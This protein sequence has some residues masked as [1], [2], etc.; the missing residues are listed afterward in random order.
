MFI[1]S[2][3]I[4][5]VHAPVQ[6]VGRDQAMLGAHLSGSSSSSTMMKCGSSK[7][8]KIKLKPLSS[9]QKKACLVK[10]ICPACRNFICRPR[11]APRTSSGASSRRTMPTVLLSQLPLIQ[12]ETARLCPLKL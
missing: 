5:A 7:P 2:V 1:C 4:T 6:Y 9:N 3:N 12:T 8:S 11:A 10:L